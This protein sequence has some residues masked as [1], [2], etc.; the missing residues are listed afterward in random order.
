MMFFKNLV[1][2]LGAAMVGLLAYQIAS[3]ECSGDT[4]LFGSIASIPSAEYLMV[5]SLASFFRIPATY[6]SDRDS[7]IDIVEMWR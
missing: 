7:L 4:H 6:S 1:L 2:G 5:L 3:H